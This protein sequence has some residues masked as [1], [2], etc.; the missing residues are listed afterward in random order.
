MIT[1]NLRVLIIED[2]KDDAL[3]LVRMLKNKGYEVDFELV[4]TNSTLR[5]ALQNNAWDIILTDHNM[6][7]FSSTEALLVI[8]EVV[9]DIPAIIV[10]GDIGEEHAVNAMRAGASDYVMKDNLKRLIPAIERELTSAKVHRAQKASAKAMQFM[11][12][13]DALTG[14]LNRQGFVNQ[15]DNILQN[16]VNTEN[17]HVLCYMDLDQFKVVND[18]CGHAA[19]DQL[20]R[21]IAKLLSD[22]LRK[23]DILAR[24]G[25]DD[26]AA[27]LEHCS[28]E[29]ANKITKELCKVVEDFQFAW[30]DKLFRLGL[31]IG[32]V[33][34]S[35]NRDTTSTLLSAADAA[36]YQAKEEGRNRVYTVDADD[37][38]QSKRLNEMNWVSRIHHALDQGLFR[39]A[40]QVIQPLAGEGTVG[41]HFEILI[42]LEEESNKLIPPGAFL[43]AAERYNLGAHIDRWVIKT[44]FKWLSGTTVELNDIHLC[45]INLSAQSISSDGFEEFIIESLEQA[46]IPPEKICFEITETIAITSL[47]R[48]VKFIER[49]KKIGCKFSLDDF[50]SGFCS[51]SYLKNLPVDYL[52]ID[53]V[54]VRDIL[55]DPVDLAMVRAINE[56]GQVM[57]K[58][59]IAE[60]VETDEIIDLLK[61]VGVDYVQGQAIGEPEMLTI[62]D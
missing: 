30:D 52:K 34:F 48:A 49:L 27:L 22:R 13:H 11:S 56:I 7:H 5:T 9:P 25:G 15:L 44:T 46:E 32:V 29:E 60:F 33:P 6:P 62:L 51:F 20:L 45:S 43:P 14:L 61:E 16:P 12:Y 26:F 2:S 19:G 58:K 4:E 38:T 28:I 59:T 47:E 41:A 42:R 37:I 3:L 40:R 18:T 10:S 54:F 31:S 1:K 21:Q 35:G 50:G 23:R 17:D 55:Q 8:Q 24:L 39:L 36:C 57:G 53:G